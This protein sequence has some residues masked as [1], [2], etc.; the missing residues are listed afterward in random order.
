MQG[1]VSLARA[2]IWEVLLAK[3]PGHTCYV[4]LWLVDIQQILGPLSLP[5]Q[6]WGV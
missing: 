4:A 3:G 1:H 2:G 6:V 5:L